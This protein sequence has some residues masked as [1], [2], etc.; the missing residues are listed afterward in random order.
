VLEQPFVI[1]VLSGP[2][3]LDQSHEFG[4]SADA[5]RARSRHYEICEYSVT[6]LSF[7]TRS[8]DEVVAYVS[9]C[10]LITSGHLQHPQQ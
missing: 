4:P 1:E 8:G 9:Q 5:C 3:H 7:G 6:R 2:C 10:V